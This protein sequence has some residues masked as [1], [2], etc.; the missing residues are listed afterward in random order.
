MQSILWVCARWGTCLAARTMQAD[1][2]CCEVM[3]CESVLSAEWHATFPACLSHNQRPT[4]RQWCCLQHMHVLHYVAYMSRM[5]V[6]RVNPGLPAPGSKAFPHALASY[7]C[8]QKSASA[9]RQYRT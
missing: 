4:A 7:L 1:T 9:Q 8:E 5:P 2:G 3:L 6:R